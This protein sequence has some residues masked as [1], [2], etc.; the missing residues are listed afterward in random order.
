MKL[1][2]FE[3]RIIDHNKRDKKSHIYKHSSENSNR[4][5]WLGNYQ[6]VGRNY[7]NRIRRKIG[8]TLLINV[9]KQSLN[10]QDKSFPLKLLN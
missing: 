10:K 8:E 5:V 7:G 4:R 1:R 6:I 2:R 3:E 9:L